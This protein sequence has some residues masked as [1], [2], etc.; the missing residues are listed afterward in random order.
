VGLLENCVFPSSPRPLS[1]RGSADVTGASFTRSFTQPKKKKKKT[2]RKDHE[3]K[4]GSKG[5]QHVEEDLFQPVNVL[6]E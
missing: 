5:E 6:E 1:P 3:G 4:A 2:S